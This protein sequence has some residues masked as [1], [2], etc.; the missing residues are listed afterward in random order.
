MPSP[1]ADRHMKITRLFTSELESRDGSKFFT[2]FFP[3]IIQMKMCSAKVVYEVDVVELPEDAPGCYWAWWDLK[4]CEFHHTSSHK[5]GVQI[6]VGENTVDFC[7]GKGQI[8]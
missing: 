5:M 8:G 3:S 1:A 7:G 2:N 4:K 6:C